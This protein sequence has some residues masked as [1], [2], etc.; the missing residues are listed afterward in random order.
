MPILKREADLYPEG[1]FDL[2]VE[3]RP[4]WVAHVRSRQEK[5]L[6]RHLQPLGIPFYLPQREQKVR[7]AGRSFV[8]YLPLFPGYLFFRGTGEDRQTA[9]R[10]ELIAQVIPVVDQ[11]L[12]HAELAQLRA[13]QETGLPLIPWDFIGPGD[14][15]V[16]ADGPF[17]GYTGTVVRTKGPLRLVV[18]V[19]M[20]RR[21]VCV[22]I[23]RE[24]LVPLAPRVERS[25]RV[26]SPAA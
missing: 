10:S 2:A 26:S 5:M 1:L 3:G 23:D 18:S 14:E 8:S 11:Q 16:V 22:E 6:A 7:R 24:A 20:L 19:T 12:L 15:I 17:R 21:S 4:W 25:G 13:L 9:L